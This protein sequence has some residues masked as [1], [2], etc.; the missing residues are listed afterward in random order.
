MSIMKEKE[1]CI[2]LGIS[3][4]LIKG[5]RETYCE[6]TH[7]KKIPTKKPENLWQ[8][9]WTD[10]GISLLR[11]NLGIKPEETVAFPEQ[12]RGTVYCKYRNPRVIGVLIDG[13]EHSVL[14]RDSVKFGIGM[15]A[16]VRWD[17]ARWVVVRHPRFNGKY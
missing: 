11:E 2:A 17:G 4:D 15:T 3:R 9:E 14:C 13:K 12:K 16:D 8:I 7:W 10:E 1:L 5:L 6:N